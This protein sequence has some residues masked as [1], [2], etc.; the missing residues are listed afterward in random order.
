MALR[1]IPPRT[2]L[3]KVRRKTEVEDAPRREA[4]RKPREWIYETRPNF[5]RVSE[6]LVDVF[7]EA[8]V[9]KIIIDLSGFSRGDIDIEIKKDRYVISAKKGDNT[10]SKEIVFPRDVDIARTEERFKNGLLEIM[11]P[12][13]SPS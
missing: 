13:K 6:P 7:K 11:L 2:S 5:K 8:E 3:D 9:V 1:S 4:V 10:F 12:R